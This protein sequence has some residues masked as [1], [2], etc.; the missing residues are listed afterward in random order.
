GAR[1]S[2]APRLP[3][4]AHASRVRHD[5]WRA[6]QPSEGNSMRLSAKS[7]AFLVLASL[8]MSGGTA[9]AA[10][11]IFDKGIEY[12]NPDDQHLQ[13]NLARP[14]QAEKRMPAVLCIHGGGFRAGNRDRWDKLCQQLAERGY[15]AATVTYRLAPKFQ[16]PAAVHDVK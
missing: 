10:E 5:A 15:V 11:I 12:S 13:L 3:T 14:K 2:R 1:G 16:F 7:V 6:I 4:D 9:R 8:Y